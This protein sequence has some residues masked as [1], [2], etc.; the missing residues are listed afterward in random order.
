M[1]VSAL[2]GIGEKR[3]AALQAAGI[4]TVADLLEYFPRDYDDRSRMKKIS[5]LN[6]DA[7]NTIRGVISREP[8]S[9]TFG[10]KGAGATSLTKVHITDSTGTLEII[11]FNQPYLKK[12]FKKGDEYIFTGKVREMFGAVQMQ[13]PEYEAARQTRS[14]RRGQESG[15]THSLEAGGGGEAS[16]RRGQESGAAHSLEAGGAF[17]SG[18]R[19]VPLYTP[20]KGFAQKAFRKLIFDAL[21]M[22]SSG[23]EFRDEK[24]MIVAGDNGCGA[25]QNIATRNSA[26]GRDTKQV[27]TAEGK[28]RDAKQKCAC[29]NSTDDCNAKQISA[30]RNSADS[31]GLLAKTGKF[32]GAT[33][34]EQDCERCGAK[35][36]CCATAATFFESCESEAVNR[37]LL[38]CVRDNQHFEETLPV[39]IL[40]KYGLCSRE[41]AIR[42]IH[43]PQSDEKFFAARRRLVF[44]ELYFVQVMLFNLKRAAKSQGGIPFADVDL[45]PFFA[46]LPFAPTDAQSRVLA[47]ITQDLSEGARMNR[48]LQGD[49][50][51]G[52]T[53]VAFAAAY[54]AAKNGFQTALMAPTDVLATQHFASCEKIFAPL[55]IEAALLTG[56]LGA[57]P[58]REALA[59]IADGTAKIIIG[60]HALIQEAVMYNNL[61]L[62]ITDEQ[63]RFGVNQRLALTFKGQ[64]QASGENLFCKK[65][66][67]PENYPPSPH[68]LVMSATPIPR[69]L[70]LILY[71]DLDVSII[72]EL[73]PGRVEI[74][75]FCVNS[76]Y[77]A[78]IHAFIEKEVALGR[79]AYVI[80]PTIEEGE[81][82]KIK[83]VQTY[84]RELAAA[85]P[86]VRVAHLHGRMKPAEKQAAMDAFKAGE[87]DVIVAT[88]VIEVG[89]HVSNAS[90]IIVE[91]AERFGLSQ[92]HQLRGRVGR[93]TAQSYCVLITDSKNQNTSTRMKA[94]TQ[95]T[96]GFRLA[97]LD[98]EQR[99]A[100]DFF[101][102]RQ[103]GLPSFKI[104]NLYRDLEILKEAQAA[105]RDHA[106]YL[107]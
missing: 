69:T 51:S 19:I 80:C 79:Q 90:L 107:L 49:V 72:N 33:H 102:T 9:A 59:K 48:L 41:A 6:P 16:F 77:R 34:C 98:L 97:E 27:L 100:G 14:E 85:L 83:N 10:R 53:A 43:F 28:G 106:N 84:T 105:A 71:G 99:G 60:T 46:L 7:V 21:Q 35:V 94:M 42:N 75:T 36:S 44:E 2:P 63:H 37:G 61:A 40:Q 52:K 104:A 39:E 74:K 25:K 47:E 57:K 30:K 22:L 17:I 4:F 18:G 70:G 103:H 26:E 20:P 58:R 88:T 68:I 73:P 11:W 50:G 24:Q 67:P 64:T 56:S 15:A 92:L 55:G 8:E 101:G 45:A 12:V 1:N 96:D 76:G 89:V 5:E 65:G 81:S 82:E 29:R 54:L 87:T 86:N 32:P 31:A 38:K 93:G 66:S 95:T 23:G 3:A 78:R 91:N 62:C 13:S